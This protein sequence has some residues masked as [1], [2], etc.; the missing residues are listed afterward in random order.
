[1]DECLYCVERIGDTDVIQNGNDLFYTRANL[2]RLFM[3]LPG[4]FPNQNDKRFLACTQVAGQPFNP[5]ADANFDAFLWV[6]KEIRDLRNNTIVLLPGETLY[7]VYAIH[8]PIAQYGV[9]ENVPQGVRSP[10]Q[11]YQKNKNQVRDFDRLPVVPLKKFATF[12]PPKWSVTSQFLLP[13]EKYNFGQRKHNT[14]NGETFERERCV[15]VLDFGPFFKVLDAAIGNASEKTKWDVSLVDMDRDMRVCTASKQSRFRTYVG[16]NTHYLFNIEII[17]EAE[18]AIGQPYDWLAEPNGSERAWEHNQVVLWAARES[19]I[20][21]YTGPFRLRFG[22]IN[23]R[24]NVAQGRL[25]DGNVRGAQ[26]TMD[27]VL[28]KTP[29]TP[30]Y[31]LWLHGPLLLGLARERALVSVREALAGAS[32]S[33]RR[34]FGDVAEP[35]F[36]STFVLGDE[37]MQNLANTDDAARKLAL[38][39]H[40]TVVA[41]HNVMRREQR[42]AVPLYE[43]EEEGEEIPCHFP[44]NGNLTLKWSNVQTKTK[45]AGVFEKASFA[46]LN[47]LSVQNANNVNVLT[48]EEAKVWFEANRDLP[49]DD[50]AQVWRSHLLV[51]A[52][53][54]T[55]YSYYGTRVHLLIAAATIVRRR[56]LNRPIVHDM[57]PGCMSLGLEAFAA[58]RRELDAGNFENRIFEVPVNDRVTLKHPISRF[59]QGG[60]EV[61]LFKRFTSAF[62]QEKTNGWKILRAV[63]ED[64]MQKRDDA[65]LAADGSFDDMTCVEFQPSVVE[66]PLY[67]PYAMFRKNEKVHHKFFVT[68]GDMVGIAKFE[69]RNAV[70]ARPARYAVVLVEH[71][72][73][74]ELSNPWSRLVDARTCE[75]NFVNAHLFYMQTGVRVDCVAWM[76]HSRFSRFGGNRG[77]MAVSALRVPMT[78]RIEQTKT[79]TKKCFAL[80]HKAA[81]RV[82][83]QNGKSKSTLYFDGRVLAAFYNGFPGTSAGDDVVLCPM[84]PLLRAT[85][86]P[87][88]AAR[89]EVLYDAQIEEVVNQQVFPRVTPS[90]GVDPANVSNLW[91]EVSARGGLTPD[92]YQLSTDHLPKCAVYFF[93]S[94]PQFVRAPDD[95]GNLGAMFRNL[96]PGFGLGQRLRPVNESVATRVLRRGLFFFLEEQASENSLHF[97]IKCNF[98]LNR[99]K[100]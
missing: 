46:G 42:D 4:R 55:M 18:M 40:A 98:L 77:S 7:K 32:M 41:L 88:T 15:V 21:V 16:K 47:M 79:H 51:D 26:Q 62:E 59:V 35:A 1:M 71:K 54:S 38:R 3:E 27:K 87:P 5:F 48:C 93:G 44:L 69:P 78:R 30:D 80:F 9:P 56:D 25:R 17:E 83:W 37:I 34:L 24:I 19:A 29:E 31:L 84:F 95:V 28:Q 73:L 52:Q 11:L 74:M 85:H 72:T 23:E 90:A 82:E 2:N 61:L 43:I 13:V 53:R 39:V 100:N 50:L 12:R 20:D 22:P 45:S 8:N 66:F 86:P 6:Y 58:P 57:T 92:V 70:P 49:H 36:D 10:N 75:Q 33:S 64:A 94:R 96:P 63:V 14:G 97:Y 67:H 81:G 89:E 99:L 68:Q 65:M 91:R 60:E 76:Y